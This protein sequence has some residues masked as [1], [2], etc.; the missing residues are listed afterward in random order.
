MIDLVKGARLTDTFQVAGRGAESAE[1]TCFS[2]RAGRGLIIVRS[3]MEEGRRRRHMSAWDGD[4]GGAYKGHL[5]IAVD[6]L[7]SV[8]N[9]TEEYLF[10]VKG[11]LVYV[12]LGVLW[13][14]SVMGGGGE[15]DACR[16]G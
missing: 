7:T 13:G 3:R 11:P 4:G 10:F 12:S 5:Q 2:S 1:R 16:R 9:I 15:C 8:T 6:M 14:G